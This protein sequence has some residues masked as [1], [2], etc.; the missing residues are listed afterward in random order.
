[1]QLK[2][3]PQQTR[4][5]KSTANTARSL[6]YRIFNNCQFRLPK[7]LFTAF[8]GQIT[9]TAT[10]TT[11]SHGWAHL[12]RPQYLIFTRFTQYVGKSTLHFYFRCFFSVFLHN[13]PLSWMM[14][15]GDTFQLITTL[16]LG[17]DWCVVHF[18]FFFAFMIT[19]KQ[20]LCFAHSAVQRSLGGTHSVQYF[21]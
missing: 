15:T 20:P 19:F 11:Q 4:I 8:D 13:S 6:L 1:M 17:I 14:T 18:R 5:F 10:N 16:L 2:R 21:R 7:S 9:P 12:L 3:H